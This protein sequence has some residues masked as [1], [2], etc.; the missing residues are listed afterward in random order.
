MKNGRKI[1]CVAFTLFSV[2][3]NSG[4]FQLL[5]KGQP[6]TCRHRRLSKP[7]QNICSRL[8][9]VGHLHVQSHLEL[10]KILSEGK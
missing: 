4:S 9:K 8:E 2:C 10:K 3:S 7:N 1:K 5:V 6:L